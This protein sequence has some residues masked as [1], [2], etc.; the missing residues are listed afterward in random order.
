MQNILNLQKWQKRIAKR[1]VAFFFFLDEWF[2]YV[3][4]TVIVKENIPWQYVP[5]YSIL[6]KAFLVEL[7]TREIPYQEAL[8]SAS[9]SILN[10][11]KLIS[12]FI[13]ILF[14]KTKLNLI[15][16]VN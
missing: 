16:F 10:N 3:G 13:T 15:F 9:I 14:A 8:T 6:L 7:K 12:I 1:G 11:E 4:K 5:G 2:K